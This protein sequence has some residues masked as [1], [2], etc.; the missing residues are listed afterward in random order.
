MKYLEG[1]IPKHSSSFGQVFGRIKCL[2]QGL[3]L[4]E[5]RDDKDCGE[6]RPLRSGMT[7]TNGAP[8]STRAPPRQLQQALAEPAD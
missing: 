2:I 7:T 4:A 1:T 6:D 3:R 5:L 8:R